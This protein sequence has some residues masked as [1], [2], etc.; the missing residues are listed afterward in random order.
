MCEYC[1][2]TD[3]DGE[4]FSLD[5]TIGDEGQ[6]EVNIWTDLDRDDPFVL[7]IWDTFKD[8][9]IPIKYCPMCGE[10]LKF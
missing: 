6:L 7:R 9:T 10:L 2:I 5:K 4:L 3:Y 8:I 1:K